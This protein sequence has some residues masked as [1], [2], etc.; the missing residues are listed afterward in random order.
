MIQASKMEVGGHGGC[1]FRHILVSLRA[2]YS[3]LYH[4]Q[5]HYYAMLS[6]FSRVRLCATP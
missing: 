2:E 6:H 5:G 1:G 4:T 3:E